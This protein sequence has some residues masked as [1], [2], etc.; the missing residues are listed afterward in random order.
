MTELI[1]DQAYFASRILL[2][3]AL[4]LSKCSVLIFIQGI[5]SHMDNVRLVVNVTIGVVILWGVAGA[6]AVSIG[7]SPDIIVGDQA[8]S[9]RVNDVSSHQ[10][11][12][13]G[14]LINHDHRFFGYE[15]LLSLT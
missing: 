14:E 11:L 3:L 4:G 2:F 1:F 6:L 8:T 10:Q 5:F 7:T 12:L 13:L 15:S 9:H